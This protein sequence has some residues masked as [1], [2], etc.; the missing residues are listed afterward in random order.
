MN[1]LTLI[2]IVIFAISALRGYQ[3][4]F[5]KSLASLASIFLSLVLVNLAN[6]YVT[7]FLKE[8]TPVYTYIEEKCGE[9]FSAALQNNAA[10]EAGAALLQDEVIESLP[11]PDVLKNMLR[12]SNTPEYYAEQA[13]RSF[14]EYVPKYMANLILTIVSFV[15][16]WILVIVFVWLAVKALDLVAN[17]PVIK[18]INQVLGL[19]VG[20]VQG[21][22]IVWIGFLVITVFSHAD[23]GRQLMS[24]ISENPFLETLYNTNILLDILTG[25]LG[26]FV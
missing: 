20:L 1:V 10:T 16:T 11:L 12:Q 14:S 6:P 15:C 4:G 8:H 7:D 22:I 2:V 5:V 9:T 25:F 19:L 3:K 13:I 24:M 21:L 26:N 18:G 23:T 17:L